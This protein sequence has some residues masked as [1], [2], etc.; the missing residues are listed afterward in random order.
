MRKVEDRATR[1]LIDTAALHADKAVLHHVD[2][3]D[4]VTAA[5]FIERLHHSQRIEGLAVHRDAVAAHELKGH[6]LRLVRSLLRA[7]GE[8]EH[9]AILGSKGI[10]PRILQNPAL[11]ADMKEISVHRVGFLG[12]GLHR[13]L[14]TAAVVDHLGAAGKFLAETLL[15]PR[16]DHLEIGRERGSGE[17]ETDLVIPLSGR[18]VGN[19]IGSLGIGDLHHALGDQRTGNAGSEEILPLVKRTRLHHREDE[20][21]GKL[22]LKVVDMALRGA[23]PKGLRLEPLELLLLADVGAEGDHLG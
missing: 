5:D 4:P 7:C 19:G 11:V 16:G 20:I 13:D 3:T 9:P 18:A 23:G 2:A 17:F 1:G 6:D 12:T 15:P 10:E 22:R 21:P 8:L 14:V